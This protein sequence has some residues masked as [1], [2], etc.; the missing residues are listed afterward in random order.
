MPGTDPCFSS[1][2]LYRTYSSFCL[3]IALREI[4]PACNVSELVFLSKPRVS[5]GNVLRTIVRDYSLWYAV[6]CKDALCSGDHFLCGWSVKS[7]DLYISRVIVD[8]DQESVLLPFEVVGGDFLP[9]Q[10]W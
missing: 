9:G 6:S 4:G 5:F 3:P 8:N 10:I 1:A 7:G 2:A